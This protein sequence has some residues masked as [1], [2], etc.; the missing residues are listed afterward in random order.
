VERGRCFSP[1][2]ATDV[3]HEHPCHRPTAER[4]VSHEVNATAT[5]P[6]SAPEPPLGD[7]VI[8]DRDP[9]CARPPCDDPAPAHPRL[10]AWC[11]LW[12]FPCTLTVP[13]LTSSRRT[14]RR[15]PRGSSQR[16]TVF[17][18]DV[19]A[20]ATSDVSCHARSANDRRCGH[21]FRVRR[22]SLPPPPRQR[23]L[24]ATTRDAFHRQVLPGSPPS[25]EGC[26]GSIPG[27]GWEPV[28]VR[29]A[30]PRGAGFRD[31]FTTLCS[32]EGW[33][34]SVRAPRALRARTNDAGH[35][36]STSAIETIHEHDHECP[37]SAAPH[38]QSPAG[39]AFL[40]E[41]HPFEHVP[42]C[43]WPISLSRA[44]QPSCYRSGVAWLATALP[45][46]FVTSPTAIARGRSFAP[47]RSTRAPPVVSRD[48][49][50][51]DTAASPETRLRAPP[52]AHP[53]CRRL[54]AIHASRALLPQALQ[55]RA[56]KPAY[57]R[58]STRSAAPEVPSIAR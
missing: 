28:T 26:R 38:P 15:S 22:G 42:G 32:R 27:I 13:A 43:G 37:S 53:A 11:E 21:P 50:R 12:S 3:R 40:P 54:R 39:A 18:C 4:I 2:S 14:P 25:R 46:P 47:T 31:P 29:L 41:A 19:A 23:R 9:R 30:W 51:P 44:G 34:G 8:G 24:L 45:C 48:E 17:G 33:L 55:A 36:L 49:C 6:T 16:R 56:A 20:R 58:R 10:T 7:L 1:A 35:R 57:P 52:T 5:P